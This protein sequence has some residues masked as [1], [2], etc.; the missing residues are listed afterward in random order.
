MQEE[1]RRQHEE[2][3]WHCRAPATTAHGPAGDKG[4]PRQLGSPTLEPPKGTGDLV[5]HMTR[6]LLLF[7]LSDMT[8]VFGCVPTQILWDGLA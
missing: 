4:G 5:I 2:T 1:M 7:F 3:A 6:F 8:G